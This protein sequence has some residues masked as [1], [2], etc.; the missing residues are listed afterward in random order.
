MIN[1][2]KWHHGILTD[3]RSKCSYLK[4][5]INGHNKP[6]HSVIFGG[7]SSPYYRFL[8]CYFVSF[9]IEDPQKISFISKSIQCHSKSPCRN[10]I[11]TKY[12]LFV[13]ISFLTKSFN[14]QNPTLNV[15]YHSKREGLTPLDL[16]QILPLTWPT[17]SG[18]AQCES[19]NRLI[20]VS[21]ICFKHCSGINYF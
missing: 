7:I 19:L 8:G 3:Q 5:L 12:D 6:I 17:S 15:V 9:T 14:A 4:L 10:R 1:K 18:H 2:L 21:W 20:D 11:M 13:M 16:T